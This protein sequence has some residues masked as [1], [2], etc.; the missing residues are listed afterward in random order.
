MVNG[1]QYEL[2]L[3]EVAVVLERTEAPYRLKVR[4]SAKK[5]RKVH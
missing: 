1:G 2:A 5:Y 4:R 3:R